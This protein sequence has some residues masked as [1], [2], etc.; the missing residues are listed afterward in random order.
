LGA[1]GFTIVD[2]LVPKE[3]G[4]EEDAVREGEGGGFLAC[5]AFT[6]VLV[7]PLALALGNDCW[8]D[9]RGGARGRVVPA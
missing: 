7:L 5:I 6:L 8:M 2:D 4:R 3:E 1:L 9:A